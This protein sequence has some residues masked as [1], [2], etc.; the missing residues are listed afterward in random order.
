MTT[1]RYTDSQIKAMADSSSHAVFSIA[2]R[3]RFGDH[4][5]IGVCILEFA[6]SDCVIDSFLLSCRVIGRG[7]EQM[8]LAHAT[9]LARSKGMA[10]LVGP[11]IPTAKNAPAEGFY[12]RTG[13]VKS[14]DTNFVA[15]LDAFDCP[16]PTHIKVMSRSPVDES[17]A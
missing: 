16:A 15:S 11:F 13:L 10:R 6:G 12:E 3:D 4:G 8:M 17:I 14:G 9:S 1:R 2:S 5:V 7:I